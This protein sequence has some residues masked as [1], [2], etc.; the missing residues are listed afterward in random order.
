MRAFEGVHRPPPLY[1][2]CRVAAGWGLELAAK[3]A[4]IA[5]ALCLQ[6]RAGA[7]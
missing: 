6:N 3:G 2:L 7:S 1:P 5:P 4:T